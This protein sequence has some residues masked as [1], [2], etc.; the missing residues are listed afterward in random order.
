MVSKHLVNSVTDSAHPGFMCVET[1]LKNYHLF[2]GISSQ[3]EVVDVTDISIGQGI[4]FLDEG[5]RD[6]HAEEEVLLY[7][8]T[9]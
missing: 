4:K 7:F 5:G 8:A 9:V 6:Y 1:P 3:R 2:K